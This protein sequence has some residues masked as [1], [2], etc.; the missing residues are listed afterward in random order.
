[1][2]GAL[3][4]QRAIADSYFA[5]AE[6][7]TWSLD[8]QEALKEFIDHQTSIGRCVVVVTSG[9]TTIPLERN[10]VRFIDNFSTGSRGA[11]S[12]E[13]FIKLGYAVIFLHRPGCV[14]PFAR[15]FQKSMAPDVGLTFLDHLSIAKDGKNIEI[16]SDDRVSQA[17]CIDALK[18]YKQAKKTNIMHA[19]P[20]V[21]V[22]EYFHALKLV[23]TAVQPLNE[24][25][26][27]YLAAAVS[28][29]Y[30]PDKELVEHKIQSHATVGQGLELHLKNVPKLLGLLRHEWA[31]Q[32]FYV[33]FKLETDETIL[34]QKALSSIANY[35]MHLVVANELK[36]RFHQVWL[37]TEAAQTLLEKPEDDLDI[38]LSLANA[39]SEMHYGFLADRHVHM[40]ASLPLAANAA[41]KYPWD[42]A[43]RS[44]AQ[45]THE[46]KTE[47]TAL[48]LGGSISML[49]H[50]L[51][52]Q[53]LK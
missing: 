50:L 49:L 36:S 31:P 39:V 34:K 15:H 11:A 6:T 41:R 37:V 33:S 21:S 24:R 9:G 38:E 40:P 7:P 46:H 10:T 12:A 13:Y 30:I 16:A 19:I 53:Y 51:Q 28:D 23:A 47:I 42:A 48:L 22:N 3:D 29:F 17:R 1:M 20:F 26:V 18:S 14:M 32:A 45:L 27:F 2:S 52:R 4:T 35:G 43:L 8:V 5:S 25:A 44:V